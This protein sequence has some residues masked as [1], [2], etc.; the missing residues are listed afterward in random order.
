MRLNKGAFSSCN[1]SGI[2]IPDNVTSIGNGAFACSSLK[3]INVSKGNMKYRSLNNCLI[4]IE[5]KELI[6]G[7]EKS[8]IPTNG[9]VTSIGASAFANCDGLTSINIPDGVTSIGAWAF[10]NCKSL[11]SINIPDSIISISNYTFYHCAN[12][13]HVIIPDSVTTIGQEAFGGCWNLTELTIPNSV[14]FIDRGAFHRYGKPIPLTITFNDTIKQWESI[15]YF[16]TLTELPS[17]FTV[18]CT[19]GDW[20]RSY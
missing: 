2:T 11:T 6:Q 20:K 5:N 7:C 8:I 19:N 4:D 10:R 17:E 15:F 3:Y 14:T 1:I 16:V 18:H 13:K 9:S 12:L